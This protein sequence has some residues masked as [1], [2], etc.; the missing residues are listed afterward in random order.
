VSSE[1]ISPLRRRM[2]EAPLNACDLTETFRFPGLANTDSP[3]PEVD[4]GQELFLGFA[5]ACGGGCGA[6]CFRVLEKR[7][8]NA[9]SEPPHVAF[10]F[11]FYPH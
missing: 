10:G 9:I 11:R 5:G 6:R 7:E 8:Q 1:R 4:H 2:I 3:F